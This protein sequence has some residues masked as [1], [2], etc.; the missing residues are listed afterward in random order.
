MTSKSHGIFKEYNSKIVSA[1][2]AEREEDLKL[3]QFYLGFRPTVDTALIPLCNTRFLPLLTR[4]GLFRA[5]RWRSCGSGLG[6]RWQRRRCR[7]RR[8]PRRGSHRRNAYARFRPWIGLGFGLG[9]SP[10]HG[11]LTCAQRKVDRGTTEAH[12]GAGRR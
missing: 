10:R 4:A 3:D 12:G 5:V 7:R 9:Y 6:T 11:K 2:K 8:F 1:D